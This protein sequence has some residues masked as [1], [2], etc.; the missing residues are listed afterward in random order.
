MRKGCAS[1]SCTVEGEGMG[2]KRGGEVRDRQGGG[3]CSQWARVILSAIAS[4]NARWQLTTALWEALNSESHLLGV[5]RKLS[6]R[7]HRSEQA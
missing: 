2:M 1:H 7:S 4:K 3:S 6:S 5:G